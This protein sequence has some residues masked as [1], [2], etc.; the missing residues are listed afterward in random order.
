[1]S[2]FKKGEVTDQ[3]GE[4][5]KMNAIRCKFAK[6]MHFYLDVFLVGDFHDFKKLI[7]IIN[8]IICKYHKNANKSLN[9]KRLKGQ[10]HISIIN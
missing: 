8:S 9:M 2:W 1:M 6:D 3:I 7:C 4:I 5:A 10:S